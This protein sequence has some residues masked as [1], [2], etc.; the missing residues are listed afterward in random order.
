MSALIERLH[1]LH[2]RYSGGVGDEA[3]DGCDDAAD[4]LD[5]LQRELVKARESGHDAALLWNKAETQLA[6]AR[7]LLANAV[8]NCDRTGYEGAAAWADRRD[9]FLAAAKEGEQ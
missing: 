6:E 4:E 8:A 3:A 2:H 9:A 5:R 7:E 1:D